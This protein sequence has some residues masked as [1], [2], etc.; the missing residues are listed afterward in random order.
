MDNRGCQL[1]YLPAYSP[2]FNP[3][4]LAFLKIKAYVKECQRLKCGSISSLSSIFCDGRECE[5]MVSS[6]WL[7][8]RLYLL[9]L[10]LYASLLLYVLPAVPLESGFV[11][12]VNVYPLICETSSAVNQM[13]RSVLQRKI[14]I[15]GKLCHK[16]CKSKSEQDCQ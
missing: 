13:T 8:L 3:I 15:Y 5:G 4:E 12:D 1:L 11:V 10:L 7:Y 2:D 14:G 6:L 16:W 9:S